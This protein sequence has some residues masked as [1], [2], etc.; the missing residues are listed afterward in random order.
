MQT[1]LLILQDQN[2]VFSTGIK[3]EK[4]KGDNISNALESDDLSEGKD[5]DF[6]STLIEITKIRDQGSGI[7]VQKSESKAES[8]EATQSSKLRVQNPEFK[9]ENPEFKVQSPEQ[10]AE[11]REQRSEAG[12]QRLE[13]RVQGTEEAQSLEPK[14]EISKFGAEGS[15]LKA[16]ISEFGVQSSKVKSESSD[17]RAESPQLKAESS[18]LEVKSSEPKAAEAESSKQKAQSTASISRDQILN[19]NF[20]QAG[21]VAKSLT[22]NHVNQEMTPKIESNFQ[23]IT[24]ISKNTENFDKNLSH[25]EPDNSP[26]FQE[27]Q[28]FSR[29]S[30]TSL[31]AKETQLSQKPLQT[32]VLTQIV[33][34]ASFNLKNGQT[35]VKID[36]KPEFLGRIQLKIS[37]ENH[38]V[39]VRILTEIPLVKDMI[40]NNINQL[41]ADLQ[42]HGLEI[43]KLDVFVANDS[44][45]YKNRHENA[46]FLK[47][48]GKTGKGE[49]HGILAKEMEAEAQFADERRGANLIGVFA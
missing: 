28:S 39:M 2:E 43:D 37:T 20:Q 13:V 19:P 27:S 29:V 12:G 1:D 10:K 46:E 31:Q 25:K 16:E 24:T 33:K 44:D 8:A 22:R 5:A 15:N 6:L 4:G 11:N 38:Q 36:L 49:A 30:D 14:S 40:E 26:L 3:S 35:E 34:K 45:Q 23:D 42:N 9:V 48:N 47:K 17:L 7:S 21:E 32:E 41:K 18:K